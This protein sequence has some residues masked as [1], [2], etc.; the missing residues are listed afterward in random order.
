MLI[1]ALRYRLQIKG[2]H[3][4]KFLLEMPSYPGEFLFFREPIKRTKSASVTAI[5]ITE[6]KLHMHYLRMNWQYHCISVRLSQ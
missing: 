5:T 1:R 2:P 3:N 4:F 6:G